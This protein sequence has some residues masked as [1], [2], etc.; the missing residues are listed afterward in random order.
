MPVRPNLLERL[1][2]YRLHRGPA[3]MLDLVGAGGLRAVTAADDLGPGPGEGYD[4]A[5]VFNVVHAHS[6][7]RTGTSWVGSRT[8]SRP[9]AGLVDVKRTSLRSAPGVSLLEA[10]R[11]G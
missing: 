9:V 10:R 8:R 1:L 6:P 3:P 11:E 4:L 7:R 5:L 2:L